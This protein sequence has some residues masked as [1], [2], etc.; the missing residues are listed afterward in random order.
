MVQYCLYVLAK[1]FANLLPLRAAYHVAETMADCHYLIAFHDRKA[2]TENIKRICPTAE[3]IPYKVREVFRNFARYLTEF[4]T[5]RK[6][7]SDP[8][9]KQFFHTD[10]LNYLKDVLE[11]G[12]GG[13]LLTAHLGNWELGGVVMGK[14]GFPVL[15]VALPHKARMV[16]DWFNKQRTD[17]G[18]GVIPPSLALRKCIEHLRANKLVALVA[19]RSF[20]NGG[21]I[22]DFMG[23]KTCFPKGPVAFAA[24]TGAAIIPSYMIREGYKKFRLVIGKPLYPDELHLK[25]AKESDWQ[26]II[27]GYARGI[28]AM[29]KAY[30]TQWLMFREFRIK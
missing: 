24:K 15:A 29:V 22:I 28:E 4:F 16:N 14:L 23:E 18:L 7:M 2:V 13:I 8:Q 9:W 26:N 10:N 5:M 3:D 20:G 25:E 17:N 6:I 21:V 27:Q 19:D 1:F 11:R 30:P 12:K